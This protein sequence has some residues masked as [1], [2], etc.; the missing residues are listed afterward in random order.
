[1]KSENCQLHTGSTDLFNYRNRWPPGQELPT[2][3]HSI[4]YRYHRFVVQIQNLILKDLLFIDTF[5]VNKENTDESRSG[6]L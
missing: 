4:T 1:M 6:I 2:W 3:Y 5:W